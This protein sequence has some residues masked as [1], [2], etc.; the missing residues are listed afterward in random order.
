VDEHV[1]EIIAGELATVLKISGRPWLSA[2]SN[3]AMQ[4]L[5]SSRFDRRQAS[6]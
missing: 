6:M 4:K 3:A 2:S 1:G 5:E